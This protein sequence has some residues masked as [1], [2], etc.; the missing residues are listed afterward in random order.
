MDDKL[1][2]IPDD[3]RPVS[4]PANNSSVE[5]PTAAADVIALAQ[6]KIE[7]V[8]KSPWSTGR[9]EPLVQ[10]A[11]RTVTRGGGV[12]AERSQRGDERGDLARGQFDRCG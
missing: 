11:E 12:R 10:F 2:P 8:A 1:E 5:P 7:L 9:R 3:C 4:I 6:Q